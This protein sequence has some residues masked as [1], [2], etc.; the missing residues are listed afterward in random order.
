MKI[1]I[2]THLNK[3]TLSLAMVGAITGTV[4]LIMSSIIT[5]NVGGTK[6][7][8]K[9]NGERV[10]GDTTIWIDKTTSSNIF[11]LYFDNKPI[12]T[13]DIVWNGKYPDWY[14]NK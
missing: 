14:F 10:Y 13:K 2:K 11:L 3:I 6:Y 12:H 4:G 8:L 9:P 7:F 5:H 1:W